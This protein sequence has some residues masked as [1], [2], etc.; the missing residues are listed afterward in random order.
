MQDFAWKN[1]PLVVL[2]D[3]SSVVRGLADRID[4]NWQEMLERDMVVLWVFAQRLR[5][6]GPDGSTE[7]G[8]AAAETIRGEL[9][10]PEESVLLVGKDGGVKGRFDT[11][12]SLET[13]FDLID[14]MPMRA[15]EMRKRS[16]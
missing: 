10:D 4:A 7:F 11:D 9:E 14:A 2:A 16:E 13:I 1:R 12:I 6:Q 3:D 15:R 5:V 8:A